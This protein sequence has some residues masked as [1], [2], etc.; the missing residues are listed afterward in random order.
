LEHT[1]TINIDE[2][3]DY[4]RKEEEKHLSKDDLIKKYGTEF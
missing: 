1:G 2:P 4:A 3:L